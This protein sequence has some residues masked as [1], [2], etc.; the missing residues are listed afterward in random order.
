M[1][2]STRVYQGPPAPSSDH[3]ACAPKKQYPGFR[4]AD[5]V[6]GLVRRNKDGERSG[7]YRCRHCSKWHV[8]GGQQL[9]AVFPKRSKR[10]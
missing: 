9:P 1:R 6:A 7:A 10:R 3:P 4:E 2:R 8:G 5:H